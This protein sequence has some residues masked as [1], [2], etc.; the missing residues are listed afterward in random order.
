MSENNDPTLYTILVGNLLH[1]MGISVNQTVDE[2]NNILNNEESVKQLK[3]NISK[4][5]NIADPL[6]DTT[7][8]KIIQ[9]WNDSIKKMGQNLSMSIVQVI[10]ILG[11]VI[12]E[13]NSIQLIF[14]NFLD[15]FKSTGD[16]LKNTLNT[17]SDEFAKTLP[18][19][20]INLPQIDMPHQRIVVGGAKI[21]S[22]IRKSVKQFM[23]KKNE[24]TN[25]EF[26]NKKIINKNLTKKSKNINNMKGGTYNKNKNYIISQKGGQILSRINESLKSFNKM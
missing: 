20:P 8:N 7:I 19:N 10:P 22:R 3:Q 13:I 5:V 18:E 1:I 15:I 4:F 14:S 21:L 25:K 6:I 17:A 24:F 16:I 12:G 23:G 2:L 26:I 11:Q 9:K